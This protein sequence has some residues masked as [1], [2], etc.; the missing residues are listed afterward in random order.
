MNVKWKTVIVGS[1]ITA[2]AIGSV[3]AFAATNSSSSANSTPG[4]SSQ[5]MF[6]RHAGAGRGPGGP[7]QF[8]D[9]AKILGVDTTTL[10]T[11]LKNGQ[12]IAQI[13]KS[14][15]ISEQ[16]LISDL[17]SNMQTQLDQAVKNGKMTA[18]QEP[19]MLINFSQHATQFVEHTGVPGFRN[20]NGMGVMGPAGGAQ[21]HGQRGT[22]RLDDVS[23]ILA[24]DVTTLQSDLKSGKSLV[25]IAQ[26]KGVS[27][28]TLVADLTTNMRSRLDVA[29]AGGKLTSQQEQQMLAKFSSHVTQFVEHQSA[30]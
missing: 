30:N 8:A 11:D 20:H 21:F 16:T 19:R 2:A 29:V 12:S 14:K 7:G 9:V 10:Q 3:T 25:T 15:G 24:I 13:A 27:E 26:S 22:G 23:K 17:K 4:T 5:G 18:A 28:A 6:H 1:L